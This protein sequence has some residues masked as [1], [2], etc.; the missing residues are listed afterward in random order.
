MAET[1][2]KESSIPSVVI[3]T[4]HR[5]EYSMVEN[6]TTVSVAGAF[7]GPFGTIEHGEPQGALE[8]TFFLGGHFLRC[9]DYSILSHKLL[10]D[11]DS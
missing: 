6:A 7:T 3:G 11:V 1:E 8:K 5:H 2:G 9:G 10:F 4:S